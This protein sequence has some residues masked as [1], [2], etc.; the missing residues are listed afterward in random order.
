M[1][2]KIIQQVLFGVLWTEKNQAR[3]LVLYYMSLNEPAVGYFN[4]GG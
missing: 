4:L 3:G 2:A 1:L